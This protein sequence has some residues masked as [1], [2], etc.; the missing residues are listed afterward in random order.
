LTG[1]RNRLL[2]TAWTEAWD[3][4]ANPGPLPLPLQRLAVGEAETRIMQF[5]N[6]SKDLSIVPVG[7]VVGQFKGIRKTTDVVQALV[8]E[9]VEAIER[10]NGLNTAALK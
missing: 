2:R 8:E 5:P 7:Q 6:Q 9:Y 3:D 10:L 1:K 4:P